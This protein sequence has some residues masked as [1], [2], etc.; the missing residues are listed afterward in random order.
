MPT[1]SGTKGSSGQIRRFWLD[2]RQPLPNLIAQAAKETLAPL[3]R[4]V[5]FPRCSAVGGDI[6]EFS[7]LPIRIR[8]WPEYLW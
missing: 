2:G 4:Q 8:F 6:H 3:H 7:P 5:H 1:G